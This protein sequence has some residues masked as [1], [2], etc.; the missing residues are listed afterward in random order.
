MANY[1]LKETANTTILSTAVD[2]T[3]QE[4]EI[5]RWPYVNVDVTLTGTVTC[6]LQVRIGGGNWT[7]IK[8]YTVSGLYQIENSFS[9][10]RAVTTSMAGATAVVLAM[11]HRR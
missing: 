10:L 4:H 7:E 11:G 1:V 5:G 2:A 3:G 6:A 9:Q 8:S